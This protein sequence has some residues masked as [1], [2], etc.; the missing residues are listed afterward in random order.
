[1]T[2]IDLTGASNG[3]VRCNI[4]CWF[5]G[6]IDVPGAQQNLNGRAEQTTVRLSGF[7]ARYL[8]LSHL[9]SSLSAEQADWPEPHRVDTHRGHNA[10]HRAEE[11]TDQRNCRT[12]RSDV[13]L[14]MNPFQPYCKVCRDVV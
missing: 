1:M 12:A 9:H 3:G 10:I 5:A 8:L 2:L 11:R 6:P 4:V 13:L 14:R 7:S